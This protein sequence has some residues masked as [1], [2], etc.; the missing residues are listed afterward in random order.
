MT[1]EEYSLCPTP[2][3]NAWSGKFGI[4]WIVRTE[5]DCW[6]AGL[7]TAAATT[8]RARR[9]RIRVLKIHAV[10]TRARKTYP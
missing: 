9:W 3:R 1:R 8:R 4:F 5:A 7:W 6:A 2:E 10:L